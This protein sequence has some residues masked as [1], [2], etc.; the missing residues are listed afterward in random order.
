MSVRMEYFFN[1][2]KNFTK[3]VKEY[4]EWCEIKEEERDEAIYARDNG[5]D[6]IYFCWNCKH[7]TCKVHCSQCEILGEPC[8]NCKTA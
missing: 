7:N 6:P 5:M 2:W 1:L 3:E 4:N 8:D